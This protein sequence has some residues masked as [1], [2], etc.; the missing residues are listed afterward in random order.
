[1]RRFSLRAYLV[2]FAM[3]LSPAILAND[4]YQE[5]FSS[6]PG[7]QLCDGV[8]PIAGEAWEWNSVDENFRV[9][10]HDTV[11]ET[12]KLTVSQNFQQVDVADGAFCVSVDINVTDASFGQPAGMRFASA[13]DPCLYD[14][15]GLVLLFEGSHDTRFAIGDW[16]GTEYYTPD[17]A[18][19]TWYRFL[20]CADPD[21]TA[22][23]TVTEVATDTA[24]LDL[25][26]VVFSPKPINVAQLGYY[27]INGEGAWSE[28]YY[29][30]L[31]VWFLESVP[32]TSRVGLWLTGLML[33]VLV[34]WA[35]SR[36]RF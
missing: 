21:G 15:G 25:T 26:D 7:Y 29:D 8:T 5:D 20:I 24:V 13:A 2:C 9:R 18:Y 34:G 27:T 28:A 32:A 4:V 1:M 17:V 12:P 19:D 6:D 16:N 23:I 33:L 14:N 11:S 10:M 30:N 36:V 31:H 35:T 3:L 22:D